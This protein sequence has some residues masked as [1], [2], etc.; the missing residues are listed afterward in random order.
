MKGRDV[1]VDQKEE[2][3]SSPAVSEPIC[4]YAD[5]AMPPYPRCILTIGSQYFDG[6]NYGLFYNDW[7]RTWIEKLVERRTV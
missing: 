4:R 5:G 1:P 6:I 7:V 2:T 3:F